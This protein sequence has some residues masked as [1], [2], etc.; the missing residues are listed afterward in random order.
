M[1]TTR[2]IATERREVTLAH[3]LYSRKGQPV[4]LQ[5]ALFG[6]FAFS[7]LVCVDLWQY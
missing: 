2:P 7:Y 5:V 1:R 4:Y 3:L 6:F